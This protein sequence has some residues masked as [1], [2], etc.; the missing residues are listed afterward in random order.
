MSD[1]INIP[2]KLMQLVETTGKL[3]IQVDNLT[4]TVDK[5][6]TKLDKM[7]K[8]VSNDSVQD[9]AIAKLTSDVVSIKARLDR[10]E[11]EKG[12]RARRIIVEILKY[13]GIACIGG[14]IANIKDIVGILFKN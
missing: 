9:T 2:E 13:L 10:L 6:N 1:D 8:L 4:T 12:E 14:V 5:M 3:S 7:D 11:R